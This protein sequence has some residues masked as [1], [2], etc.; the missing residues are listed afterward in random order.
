M[1]NGSDFSR[2]RRRSEDH[3]GG[4]KHLRLL[5][6]WRLKLSIL[7]ASLSVQE[8]LTEMGTYTIWHSIA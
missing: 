2:V 5:Q 7:W 1:Q 4:G 6:S 8:K 3:A